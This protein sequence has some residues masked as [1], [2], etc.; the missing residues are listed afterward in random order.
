MKI[1]RKKK[2]QIPVGLYCY[3]TT[4]EFKNL[5]D[6]RYGFTVKVCPFYT[7][8]RYINIP[9]SQLPNWVDKEWLDE[10]GETETDWCRLVN[11]EIDDQCKSCGE[12]YGKW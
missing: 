4:S 1:P 11:Y 9:E 8:K 3:T 7:H 12:R 2:K 10:Y 5:G 6:G